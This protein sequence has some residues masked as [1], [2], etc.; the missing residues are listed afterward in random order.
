MP[1]SLRR[2]AAFTT[3][4]AGGNPAGVWI[5]DALPEP[6]EM[7]KIAADIGYSET[8]FV[9]PV[10]GSVRT[11]RYFSP[12]A[13][14]PFCGHA[15]IAT[16]VA[17]GPDEGLGDFVLSSSVGDIAV[18]VFDGPLGVE[19]SLT[20]VVPTH[21]PLAPELLAA[22]LTLLNWTEA[23]LDGTLAPVLAYAGAWH[24]IIATAT[25]S[26][27]K[28]LEYDFDALKELMNDHGLTTLQLVH[29]VGPMLFMS[30][31]PFPVGGVTE[32]PATGA[33]AAALGGYLRDAE[34]TEVPTDIVIHQ[35]ADMGRPSELR[36]SIPVA[37]GITVSG[38]A[39][40]IR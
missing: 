2:I 7:Q 15:T 27:L 28:D 31:N 29:R 10:S 38:N 12:L 4:P 22:I 5:G 32:D 37:G 14:V 11:I 24:A 6:A 9:A 13:E 30:R 33:A 17:L 1:P 26:R 20:S 21:K 35:G 36:V 8:A 34:L 23:E 16:G 25:H 19:A 40:T 3:D 18:H 39:V